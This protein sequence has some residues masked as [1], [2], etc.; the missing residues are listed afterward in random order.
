MN[1]LL[2]GVSYQETVFDRQ[3]DAK[4]ASLDVKAKRCSVL[5]SFEENL[6]IGRAWREL[7]IDKS[8]LMGFPNW[9]NNVLH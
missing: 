8:L 1:K 2:M 5:G 3:T 6:S 9:P 7:S 4:N